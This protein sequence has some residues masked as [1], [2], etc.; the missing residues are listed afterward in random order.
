ML[1]LRPSFF[2]S[3]LSQ[4]LGAGVERADS[5]PPRAGGAAE[6][7]RKGRI[8]R[9]VWD[10]AGRAALEAPTR[11]VP[12]LVETAWVL[13]R[14]HPSSCRFAVP[15][16]PHSTASPLWVQSTVFGGLFLLI[17]SVLWPALLP[18]ELAK[19]ILSYKPQPHPVADGFLCNWFLTCRVHFE[20]LLNMV[21]SSSSR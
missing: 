20:S 2:N 16:Q 15:R 17:C 11:C 4:S 7:R 3:T 18:L 5:V 9:G 14:P 10:R 13:V 1:V 6:P 19:G 21:S 8:V 12:G